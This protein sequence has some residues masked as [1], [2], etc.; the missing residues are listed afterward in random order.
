MRGGGYVRICVCVCVSVCVCVCVCVC[1]GILDP[2]VCMSV[3][4]GPYCVRLQGW[5]LNALQLCSGTPSRALGG[6]K[7]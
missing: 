2:R 5:G 7:T 1:T 4:A 3:R 6:F